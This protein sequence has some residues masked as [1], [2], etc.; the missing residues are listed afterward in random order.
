MQFSCKALVF[1]GFAYK[2]AANF[3]SGIKKTGRKLL[4]NRPVHSK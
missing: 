2:I 1:C 4:G 3:G